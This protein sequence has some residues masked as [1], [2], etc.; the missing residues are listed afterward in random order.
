MPANEKLSN[1]FGIFFSS[2]DVPLEP[3]QLQLCVDLLLLDGLQP[4]A[5]EQMKLLSGFRQGGL[6]SFD[7]GDGHHVFGNFVV[8]ELERVLP[9]TFEK[10]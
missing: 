9:Q 10:F 4:G 5:V 2:L 1:S 8:A 7:V 3:F 6:G